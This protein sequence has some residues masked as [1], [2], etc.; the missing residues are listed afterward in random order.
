MLSQRL[1]QNFLYVDLLF[2]CQ[3]P[4]TGKEEIWFVFQKMKYTY[5]GEE[6]KIFVPVDFPCDLHLKSYMEWKGYEEE[7]QLKAAE[8]K[9]GKNM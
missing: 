1:H 2:A 8:R 9:Y 5:D 4:T 3:N 6:K 7:E